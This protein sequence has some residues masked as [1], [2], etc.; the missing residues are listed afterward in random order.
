MPVRAVGRQGTFITESVCRRCWKSVY[1]QGKK[2][3]A[4]G[5]FDTVDGL[6]KTYPASQPFT[7]E[8]EKTKRLK[9]AS[10]AVFIVLNFTTAKPLC[11]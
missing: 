7:T 10:N 9:A 6:K 8:E 4:R 1:E 3:G 11:K 2:D 5:V